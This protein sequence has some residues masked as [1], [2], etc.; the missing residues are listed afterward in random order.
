MPNLY[1]KRLEFLKSMKSPLYRSVEILKKFEEKAS[2]NIQ[3]EIESLQKQLLN[4]NK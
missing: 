4:N 3:T 2:I 1:S